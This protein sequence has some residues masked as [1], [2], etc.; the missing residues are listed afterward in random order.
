MRLSA[1]RM[2]GFKSFVDPTQLKLES[3]LTGVVGPNGCGKSNVIDAVR[4]VMGESSAKQLRGDAMEDVIFNGSKGRKPVGRASVEIVF[5]NSAGKLG[6]QYASYAEI[7][8]KR[9]LSRDGQSQYFLN[10]KR[11]RRR[12]IADIFLGTGLGGKSSYAIIQQ[13]TVSRFVEAKPE[14]M[15]TIIEEAAGISKYKERRRETENRIRHTR[16]NLSRLD[17]LRAELGERLATLERQA[18]NAEKY[19]EYKAQERQLKAELV[20]LKL[21]ALDAEAATATQRIEAHAHKLESARRASQEAQ[22]AADDSRERQQQASEALQTAQA[23]FYGA[24]A[25]LSRLDQQIAH[26]REMNELRLR[27]HG[28]LVREAE[29]LD[30]EFQREQGAQS[31]VSSG[32]DDA[33][34][35]LQ[36]ASEAE[37]AAQA[38]LAEADETLAT[39]QKHWDA[40][41]DAAST[42]LRDAEAQRA[43]VE[44]QERRLGE[45]AQRLQRLGEQQAGVDLDALSARVQQ[46]VRSHEQ[47]DSTA[48]ALRQ[49]LADVDEAVRTHRQQRSAQE[50]TLDAARQA[51]H[52]VRGKL[53]SLEALQRAALADDDKQQRR[54]LERTALA[55]APRLAEQLQV[56]AGY[57][58][59]VEAALGQWLQAVVS[60]E[61]PGDTPPRSIGLV[62]ADAEVAPADDA[63][64]G[65]ERLSDKVQGPGAV[66]ALL[67]GCHVVD[68]LPGARALQPALRPGQ[69][70]L[71][72]QGN[73]VG[74]GYVWLAGAQAGGASVIVR[75]RDIQA[76]RDELAQRESEVEQA[77]QQIADTRAALTAAEQQRGE[78]SAQLDQHAREAGQALAAR[79]R[80]QVEHDQAVQRL[81][82]ARREVGELEAGRED[83]QQQLSDA[84]RKLQGLI[85]AAEQAEAQRARVQQELA[86]ARETVREARDALDRA[87]QA[88]QDANVEVK[89]RESRLSGSRQRLSE[90]ESRRAEVQKRL[91]GFDDG[92]GAPVQS[93][94][95]LEARRGPASDDKL[96]AETALRRCREALQT[97]D[98]RVRE[99]AEAAR[100]AEAAVE[101]L[102]DTLQQARLAA[103]GLSVR[104]QTLQEQFDESGLDADAVRAQ[105]DADA[106]PAA[107]TERLEQMER[108]IARLGAINLAAIDEFEEQKQRAD[109]LDAQHA[110]LTEALE[111]LTDAIEKIDRETKSRFKQTF[112][113]VNGHFKTRFPALFGGGEAYLE[114]TGEDLL[115]TGIRVMAR[116]PGK[117]NASI[118]MLSG[119]EKAM[120]AVA[121]LFALFELTPAPFC[122]LDEVDAPLDDANVGRYCAMIRQMSEEVQFIIITHNKLTM[123]LADR[124]HGVTMAEP[125][126]S[127]LVTVDMDQALEMAG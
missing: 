62:V 126:V 117:R 44:N 73:V 57:E 22:Q 64:D 2:S 102:R 51:L 21:A 48:S 76:L 97:A 14:E 24:E 81:E 100:R 75:E 27:E 1:I 115:D 54:W 124:L 33:R 114:L 84:R 77:Q 95:T 71:D 120:T 63:L 68:D 3:A 39:A 52:G 61:T 42:P 105:L 72:R 58:R 101:P 15:R 91:A 59:A 28:Q 5:D 82:T 9:E 89:E 38:R 85:D 53:A 74:P 26:A 79:E 86:T 111:Q 127:R 65:A 92:Q 69:R 45:F 94:E 67:S 41:V 25:E 103:E 60:A 34:R 35:R 30:A 4:W 11:C 20:L 113:T 99:L 47:A 121:L 80:A 18:R 110:D 56:D 37:Q 8:V 29:Q 123:E 46:L 32:L 119:G 88:R 108:R 36:E 43:R 98:A 118:A 13:G 116:P 96:A 90:L 31:D 87:R 40:A 17:D 125:G 10:G 107:W 104:R 112:E 16:E 106:T 6:G 19:K 23:A 70:V 12:D 50:Q 122:M 109:Y 55:S 93:I 49:Q 7:A 83:A 66:L 78:L